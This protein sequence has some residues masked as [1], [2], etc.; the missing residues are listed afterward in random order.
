MLYIAHTSKVAS[1]LNWNYLSISFF[2]SFHSIV[3]S[4]LQF[5]CSFDSSTVNALF[6]AH[7]LIY[8]HL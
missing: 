7:S 4:I 5:D 6:N 3:F 8:A 1:I 2:I